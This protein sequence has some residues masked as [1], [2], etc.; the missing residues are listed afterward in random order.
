MLEECSIKIIGREFIW[1]TCAVRKAEYRPSIFFESGTLFVV[2]P[3]RNFSA[4]T[5]WIAMSFRDEAS[6]KIRVS[7][8][9]AGGRSKRWVSG[10]VGVA[11]RS[12]VDVDIPRLWRQERH[13]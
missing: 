1:H 11:S 7:D 13:M 3:F 9:G 5:P 8:G 2:K 4:S 6:L 12:L 10:F